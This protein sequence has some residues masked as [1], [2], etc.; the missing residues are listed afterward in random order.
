MGRNKK[1]ATTDSAS[2]AANCNSKSYVNWAMQNCGGVSIHGTEFCYQESTQLDGSVLI[3]PCKC[4]NPP[5]MNCPLYMKLGIS[6]RTWK[7]YLTG[8]GKKS[9]WKDWG[10]IVVKQFPNDFPVEMNSETIK[11]Q[12]Q[13]ALEYTKTKLNLTPETAGIE[14]HPDLTPLF[15]LYKSIFEEMERDRLEKQ[16]GAMLNGAKVDS[17]LTF[18]ASTLRMPQVVGSK[19][20]AS[21]SSRRSTP[22]TNNS[23]ERDIDSQEDVE[24]LIP[25][26]LDDFEA[27]GDKLIS[28]EDAEQAVVEAVSN[29]S[30]TKLREKLAAG[31]DKSAYKDKIRHR[32]ER[33][34]A[35]MVVLVL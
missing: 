12:W 35:A 11:K 17:M 29:T 2:V 14:T 1:I 6:S 23:S 7:P 10:P 5:N 20:S 21:L 32:K 25:T 28:A 3:G 27:G 4:V 31:V 34:N 16:V 33:K 8:A 13:K 24:D 19:L 22:S 18:E 26:T 15:K 30:T 9:T